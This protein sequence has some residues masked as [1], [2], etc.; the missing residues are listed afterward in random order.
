MHFKV[1]LLVF[2]LKH[3]LK[4][5]TYCDWTY[6]WWLKME[7]FQLCENSDGLLVRSSSLGQPSLCGICILAQF[8]PLPISSSPLPF[9]G[10]LWI[11]SI[12]SLG[13]KKKSEEPLKA[14]SNLACNG[15]PRNL[16]SYTWHNCTHLCRFRLSTC[17]E[18]HLILT[19]KELTEICPSGGQLMDNLTIY[20]FTP[21]LYTLF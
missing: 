7:N 13:W 21:D 18:L 19:Q 1:W 12:H 5:C 10:V 9:T 3:L 14:D 8:L 17:S 16:I 11:I 15:L 6:I 20:E 4:S 2:Y